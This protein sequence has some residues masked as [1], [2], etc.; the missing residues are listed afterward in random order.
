MSIIISTNIDK[1]DIQI[2]WIV[3][4]SLLIIYFYYSGD[5]K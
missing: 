5:R 3:N 1:L 4:I 2:T